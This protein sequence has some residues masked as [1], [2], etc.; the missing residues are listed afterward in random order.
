MNNIAQCISFEGYWKL[1]VMNSEER[2]NILL[3]LY[4]SIIEWYTMLQE[5]S[6]YWFGIGIA[7][8]WKINQYQYNPSF[9][10][11]ISIQYNTS[12]SSVRNMQTE[13]KTLRYLHDNVAYYCQNLSP[14][15]SCLLILLP[16][17]YFS[18]FL[19]NNFSLFKYLHKMKSSEF[20]KECVLWLLKKWL[21]SCT[22]SF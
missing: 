4:K 21:V 20:R 17:K 9:W 6:W 19:G 2:C 1:K 15:G 5:I 16:P 10:Y 3:F 13:W 7:E 8:F 12:C 14:N 11:G 18:C 22:M